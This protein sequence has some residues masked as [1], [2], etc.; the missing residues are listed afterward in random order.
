MGTE[1]LL[2]ALKQKESGFKEETV[3]DST[4]QWLNL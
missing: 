4:L 3:R 1:E 2:T